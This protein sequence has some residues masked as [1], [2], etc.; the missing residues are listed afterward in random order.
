M[1]RRRVLGGL[2]IL[3][4]IGV[5]GYRYAGRPSASPVAR[6][7][8]AT[9]ELRRL[10]ADAAPA[11]PP[12]EQSVQPAN[13][14]WWNVPFAAEFEAMRAAARAG[15]A[16]AAYALGSRAATCMREL[17]E[18]SPASILADYQDQLSLPEDIEKRLGPDHLAVRRRNTANNT[19][20]E[21]DRYEN[22]AA[23]GA[24]RM[25]DYLQWLEQAGAA[26]S[27]A[28][29]L[30]YVSAVQQAYSDDRGALIAQ[31]E[32]AGRRRT[33]AR[34]WL[35]E[36]IASGDESAF[37]LYANA[38]EGS[39]LYRADYV[40]AAAYGYALELAQQRRMGNFGQRWREGLRP[41]GDRLTPA[42][43]AEASRRGRELFMANLQNRPVWPNGAPPPE[44]LRRMQA[45]RPRQ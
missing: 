11:R 9:M 14:D 32:E 36:R 41:Y 5:G 19:A 21:L 23:I 6:D 29:R 44:I 22:C 17:R 10:L 4:A 7:R 20:R 15:D 26:G 34:E 1:K 43:W 35:D 24:A 12:V 18:K 31:I 45:F 33:L 37:Q 38:L 30:S 27:G 3:V 28:A 8:A 42:Q 13:R 39:W 25:A 40:R 2:L 16:S